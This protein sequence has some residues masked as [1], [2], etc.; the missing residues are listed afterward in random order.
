MAIHVD[1]VQWICHQA[2]VSQF[3]VQCA[4]IAPVTIHADIFA[5][6]NSVPFALATHGVCLGVAGNTR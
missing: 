1:I 3:F 5:G 6:M 4:A 2:F